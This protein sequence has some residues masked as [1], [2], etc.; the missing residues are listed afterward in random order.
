[1]T[2]VP[3][4]AYVRAPRPQ[5]GGPLPTA[6][7]RVHRYFPGVLFPPRTRVAGSRRVRPPW[8]VRGY[9]FGVRTQFDNRNRGKRGS[10]PGI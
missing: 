10:G 3:A 1:M 5:P 4:R 7:P 8:K 6:S 9:P 2:E